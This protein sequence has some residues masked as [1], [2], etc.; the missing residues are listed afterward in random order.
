MIFRRSEQLGLERLQR[1]K[2]NPEH[3]IL[4]LDRQ[5]PQESQHQQRPLSND[6]IDGGQPPV[7]SLFST[8]PVTVVELV[9]VAAMPVAV[10]V[11]PDDASFEDST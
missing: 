5:K 4:G 11:L 3:Q 8:R 9:A 1:L 7:Q 10:S 6:V 2:F